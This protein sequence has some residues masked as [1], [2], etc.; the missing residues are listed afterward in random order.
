M[1]PA[2]RRRWVLVF[3]L[4]LVLAALC[5]APGIAGAAGKG[6]SA[7]KPKVVKELTEL[8]T[9]NSKTYLLSNGARQ[10]EISSAPIQFKDKSGTWKDID[11][12]LAFSADGS[13][14][15]KAT[16]VQVKLSKKDKGAPVVS[17]DYQGASI[18]LALT[19]HDFALPTVDGSTATYA[20]R[21]DGQATPTPDSTTEAP[22]KSTTTQAPSTTTSADSTTDTVATPTSAPSVQGALAAATTDTTDPAETTTSSSVVE[23]TTSET[24]PATQ[25]ETTT[26]QPETTTTQASAPAEVCLSYQVLPSGLKE[27]ISLAS[28][29]APNTYTFT[30]KHP[31]LTLLKDSTGTWAFYQMLEDGPQLILGGLDVFDSSKDAAGFPACADGATMTVTPGKDESTITYTVPSA[32]LSDPARIFPVMIDPTVTQPATADTFITSGYPTTSYGSCTWSPVGYSGASYYQ[33]TALIK[34]DLPSGLTTGGYVQSAHFQVYQYYKHASGTDTARASAM[35]AS[36]STS[37]TYSSLGSKSWFGSETRT[38]QV[39]STQ[40]QW[41]DFDFTST[42]QEWADGTLPNYGFTLYQSAFDADASRNWWRQVYLSEYSNSSLRPKLVITYTPQIDASLSPYNAD[43][44]GANDATSAI[45][46]AITAADANGGTVYLPAGNYK[47]SGLNVNHSNLILRGSGDNTRLMVSSP[48]Q[49]YTLKIGGTSAVSNVTVSNLYLRMPADGDGIQLQ[50]T[51]GGS[52]ITLTNLSMGGGADSA[53]HQAINVGSNFTDLTITG[54]NLS[55]V[56]ALGWDY[57]ASATRA[58]VSGN[59]LYYQ[60]YRTDFFGGSDRYETAIRMSRASYPGGINLTGRAVVVALGTEYPSVLAAGPLANAYS[61][62]LLL[63]SSSTALDSTVR[64][65]LERLGAPTIFLVGLPDAVYNDVKDNLPACTVTKL[66]GTSTTDYVGTGTAVAT[67]IKT[68]KGSAVAK[69]IIVPYDESSAQAGLA[70]VVPLAAKNTWPILFTPKTGSFP[71]GTSTW[72]TTAG[73]MTTPRYAVEV[74]T[75]INITG[76]FTGGVTQIDAA[77]TDSAWA[78]AAH[79]SGDAS[80]NCSYGYSGIAS[81]AS[82]ADAALLGSYLGLTSGRL[83]LTDTNG[84]LPSETLSALDYVAL[85]YLTYANLPSLFAGD[86]NPGYWLPGS[87]RHTTYDLKSFADHTAS[88]LLDK[89]ALNVDTTDLEIASYGPRAAL[90]RHY[91]SVATGL[92]TEYFAPGWHFSFERKLDLGRQANGRVDFIDDYGETH[93]FLA[94]G[95]RWVSAPGFT[96][97]LVSYS[98]YSWTMTLQDG[99]QIQFNQDGSLAAE[100]DRTWS[101]YVYYGWTSGKC[102]SITAANHQAITLTYSGSKVATATYQTT[103]GTRTVTYA[104]GSPWTVTYSYSGTPSTPSR[105]LTYGYTSNVLTGITATSFTAT[106]GDSTETFA[107]TSGALTAAYFPDYVAGSN[108][109]PRVGIAY[110]GSQ[111]TITTHGRIYSPAAANLGSPSAADWTP[112]TDVTQVFTWNP[113][114]TMASKTN[115]KTSSESTQT[116]TYTYSPLTN[117]QASETDPLGQTKYWTYNTRGDIA[118]DTDVLGNT[119]TYTYPDLD[120]LYE[121]S[122]DVRVSSNADDVYDLGTTLK[123]TMLYQAMGRGSYA[124]SPGWRFQNVQI[125]KGAVIT[126]AKLYLTAYANATGDPRQLNNTIACEAAPNPGAWAAGSHEPVSATL[127]SWGTHVNTFCPLNADGYAEWIAGNTYESPDIAL[128]VQEVIGTSGWQPGNALCVACPDLGTTGT[129]FIQAYDYSASSANAALLKV[130]WGRSVEPDLRRDL[131]VTVTK[132]D[133]SKTYNTYDHVGALLDTRSTVDGTFSTGTKYTYQSNDPL[134][135]VDVPGALKQEL[136]LVD[137]LWTNLVTEASAFDNAAWAKTNCLIVPNIYSTPFGAE[138]TADK[139]CENN[140]NGEHKVGHTFSAVAGKKYRF[141]VYAKASDFDYPGRSQVGLTFG[142]TN[143]IFSGTHA[144]FETA[145]DTETGYVVLSSTCDN[146]GLDVADDYWIRLWVEETANATGTAILYVGLAKDGSLSYTGTGHST[147]VSGDPGVYLA[148]AECVDVS[149]VVGKDYDSD[150]YADNGQPVTTRTYSVSLGSGQPTDLASSDTYNAFGLLTSR[151]DTSGQTVETDTYDLAGRLLTSTGPA[152]TATVGGTAYPGNHVV[153]HHTYDAWGHETESYDQATADTQAQTKANWGTSRYDKAGRVD[154]TK[155]WLF[156]SPPPIGTPQSTTDYTYDGLGRPILQSN[157]TVSNLPALTAYDARG[158]VVADWAGGACSGSY[159]LVMA[160]RNVNSDT[161]PNATPAY[162]AIGRVLRS[163]AAG[164][165]TAATCE[166]SVTD[167]GANPDTLSAKETKPDGSWTEVTQDA[168]GNVISTESSTSGGDPLSTATYDGL[169][170][171]SSFTVLPDDQNR[172]STTDY[173]YDL[174]G[175]QTEATGEGSPSQFTYNA[176][177]W[178]LHSTDPDGTTTTRFYDSAGRV[179]SE[180][181]SD[182]TNNYTT[183]Y[184]YDGAGNLTL[185]DDP[186]DRHTDITYDFFGRAYENKQTLTGTPRVTVADTTTSYDSLGRPTTV[187][188]S[189]HLVTHTYSYPQNTTGNTTDTIEVGTAGVDKVTTTVTVSADGCE[190]TRASSITSGLSA[191]RTVNNRENGKRVT[192][193]SISAGQGNVYSQYAYDA[194]GHL[195]RQWGTTGG[196]GGYTAT[197]QDTGYNSYTYSTT[198]GLK[199][200]DEIR[201]ASV[202]SAGTIS[203]SYSYAADGRLSSATT[204]NSTENYTWDA[205]G[206]LTGVNSATLTYDANNRLQSSTLGGTTTYFSYNALGQRTYQGATQGNNPP[207]GNRSTFSYTGT[208]RLAEY[209]KLGTGALTAKY[210]Y[211]AQG[212]RTTSDVEYSGGA[213]IVT[214]FIYEGLN[215]TSLTATQTR[216]GATSWKITYLYDENGRPYMGVY[217]TPSTNTSPIVFFLVTTDRGDVVELLDAAGAPFAAYRYDAWGNPQ[218]TGTDGTGI[219]TTTTTLMNDAQVARDIAKRQVLRYAGYC[220]DALS[221]TDTTVGLYYLSARSYDPKTRQFLSQDP[222]RADGEESG[223]QYCAGNPVGNEDPSGQLLRRILSYTQ[224]SNLRYW[225]RWYANYYVAM[226][227]PYYCGAIPKNLSTI[228]CNGLVQLILS[229]AGKQA[230]LYKNGGDWTGS[231]WSGRRNANDLLTKVAYWQGTPTKNYKYFSGTI[232]WR[233]GDIVGH[234]YPGHHGHVT[235]VITDGPNP[236]IAESSDAP[237]REETLKQ[238]WAGDRAHGINSMNINHSARFFAMAYDIW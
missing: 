138:M 119:T 44:T 226:K 60:P 90:D 165:T 147:P 127:T 96:A 162:D 148:G 223:Y 105:S 230:G 59:S 43:K 186:D 94:Q 26:T 15:S 206:N 100:H 191:T 3:V 139:I 216:V 65:E 193:A 98:G 221:T 146:A 180:A 18:E 1:R 195:I 229:A 101:N 68:K 160:T 17:L 116:W 202:G 209:D 164:D 95:S 45:N 28:S 142:T 151:T 29:A 232:A 73:N 6:T 97:D 166:Y 21:G 181:V 8:K 11:T 92:S 106:Y 71:S 47:V 87:A 55:G 7:A 103:A 85:D 197:A 177:G 174:L 152:F 120:P 13:L 64:D 53:Q 118:S 210:T 81:G 78:L 84:A 61:G 49:D 199:T 184:T 213:E 20:L 171:T 140:A 41:L 237:T 24:P 124:D 88:V 33:S 86:A 145:P 25:P 201:L 169:D 163:T 76:T 46:G 220:W 217:R 134:F 113:S 154:E 31:G 107:Y 136:S 58:A 236:T 198:S 168:D 156:S 62:P 161:Y 178:Q 121:G 80:N 182:Q 207:D 204:N 133:G 228:D 238:R 187:A 16:P 176:L 227:I 225:I 38:V 185:Q 149:A 214:S 102:T 219:W 167:G 115:P 235:I 82:W 54:N 67:Q 196:G 70:A 224:Y 211:D 108:A 172:A 218:G 10:V 153:S 27:V 173:D 155:R 12:T 104:T 2:G 125:P 51:G 74:D 208:G 112:S 128:S 50:G 56:S 131:P 111:A 99:T 189:I 117:L 19:G 170:Q 200:A 183:T 205:A 135:A 194:A 110:N 91:S 129:N 83:L 122:L 72:C 23:T 203:S 42:V 123:T 188:D 109:D 77:G 52:D 150:G 5:L 143:G 179:L 231:P 114:G 66:I 69:V 75:S 190:T 14:V 35:T 157:S 222:A 130:T 57:S 212:Q 48:D 234:Y 141:S 34:F 158:D 159:P 9:E 40:A 137:G 39:S 79:V 93:V 63:N 4:C 144:V 192:N 126:S 132:P 32:W 30:L 36:W 89:A 233:I 175:R 22:A 215:L 37:S